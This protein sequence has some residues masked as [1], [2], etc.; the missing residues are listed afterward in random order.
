MQEMHGKECEGQFLGVKLDADTA[1]GARQDR[2]NVDMEHVTASGNGRIARESRCDKGRQVT[3]LYNTARQCCSCSHAAQKIL[4]RPP[5]QSE[6]NSSR[7]SGFHSLCLVDISCQ[8]KNNDANM[9]SY[10]L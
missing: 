5:N 1:P 3:I 6:T 8:S 4:V 10:K 7:L 9:A 2:R